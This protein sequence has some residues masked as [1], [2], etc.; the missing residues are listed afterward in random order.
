[1]RD[2]KRETTPRSGFL[3]N[4]HSTKPEAN[5]IDSKALLD[6]EDR[7]S[8]MIATIWDNNRNSMSQ[9][10]SMSHAK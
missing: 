3:C 8:G 4:H 10:G 5:F 1:M 2:K 7:Y 9:L 6:Y